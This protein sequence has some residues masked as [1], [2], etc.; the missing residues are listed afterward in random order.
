MY[1]NDHGTTRDYVR[2]LLR[3]YRDLVEKLTR[4][5]GAQG[6]GLASE[7]LARQE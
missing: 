2:I 3:Q 4:I 6:L 1:R 7:G 5:A